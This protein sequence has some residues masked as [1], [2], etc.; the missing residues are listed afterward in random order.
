[1]GKIH[2]VNLAALE[3]MRETL[4]LK[5]YSPNTIRTYC[6]EL[7]QLLY[8]I[9]DTAVDTLTQERLR[10]YLLYCV[11]KLQLSENI[12]HSRMNAIKFYF[13]QV[14]HRD[15]MFFVEIPR[16][17]KRSLLPKVISKGDIAKIFAQ[18]NNPK[19]A[20]I[21]KLCYGMGLRHIHADE[22]TLS[23]CSKCLGHNG[24]RSLF[25]FPKFGAVV[26]DLEGA[27]W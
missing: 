19:H 12:I 8:A 24:R 3:R 14:L 16:P 17:Q 4:L 21:L 15:K 27:G 22:H 25:R 13:E 10:A 20:L 6:I 7:A 1:M 18:V 23:P 2:P 11:T 5:A 26:Q 9:K